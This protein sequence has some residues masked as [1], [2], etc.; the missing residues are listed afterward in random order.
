MID[1]EAIPLSERLHSRQRATLKDW[2]NQM[3]SR[4]V[5]KPIDET[6]LW[7]ARARG[8]R[9]LTASG[10][11]EAMAALALEDKLREWAA[12]LLL[13]GRELPAVEK[14][15]VT[16]SDDAWNLVRVSTLRRLLLQRGN[17]IATAGSQR[18]RLSES[19]IEACLAEI[20]AVVTRHALALQ[21]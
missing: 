14:P 19:T 10:G 12:G 18:R 4:I 8:I 11:S 1:I 6:D 20:D 21:S 5:S 17:D 7:L 3:A 15:R 16:A 13:D 2:L 9:H